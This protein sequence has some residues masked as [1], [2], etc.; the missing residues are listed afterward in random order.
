MAGAR[1]PVDPALVH[2]G[3]EL[4][5]GLEHGPLAANAP[6]DQPELGI[7]QEGLQ[8]GRADRG[9]VGPDPDVA[10]DRAAQLPRAEPQRSGPAQPQLLDFGGAAAARAE[11]EPRLPVGC[12]FTDQCSMAGA[13]GQQPGIAGQRAIDPAAP[14]AAETRQHGEPAWF[15]HFG[16]GQRGEVDRL[17]APGEQRVERDQRQHQ[18]AEQGRGGPAPR[19][20]HREQQ[21]RRSRS[22]DQQRGAAGGDGEGAVRHLK[23]LSILRRQMGRWQSL[24]RLTEG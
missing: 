22:G 14:A 16:I 19:N 12:I 9:D 3:L 5:Q 24:L 4:A 10:I 20:Q 6:G 17:G 23:I 7:A 11:F 15:A 8:G 1:F 21:R 18:R 2:P 13:A